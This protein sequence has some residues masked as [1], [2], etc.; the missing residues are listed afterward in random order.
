MLCVFFSLL[1]EEFKT[2]RK[3]RESTGRPLLFYAR[4]LKLAARSM[5][6]FGPQDDNFGQRLRIKSKIFESIGMFL[7]EP[8]F[9]KT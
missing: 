3:N 8:F 5:I 2:V 9:R 7:S 4:G 6:I 1:K